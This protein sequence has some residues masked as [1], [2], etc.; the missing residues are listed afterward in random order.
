MEDIESVEH[1][2][3][4]AVQNEMTFAQSALDLKS[5]EHIWF[6]IAR[7]FFASQR[8]EEEG[9]F[10]WISQKVERFLL[11]HNSVKK[12]EGLVEVNAE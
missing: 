6:K 12:A 10:A 3:V 9:H 2:A 11:A 1:E 5:V 7:V 8:E 4:F